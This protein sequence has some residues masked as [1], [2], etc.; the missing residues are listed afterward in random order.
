[1][2]QPDP[3]SSSQ[4]L[5]VVSEMSTCARSDATRNIQKLGSHSDAEKSGQSIENIRFCV[6]L[7]LTEINAKYCSEIPENFQ[8]S[9]IE[10]PCAE[11][12]GESSKTLKWADIS[13]INRSGS[14]DQRGRSYSTKTF[15]NLLVRELKLIIEK[16]ITFQSIRETFRFSYF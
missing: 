7:I 6:A 14:G 13:T 3:T 11:I 4:M 15:G 9:A 5:R 12:C 2:C 1:M 10:L 8:K 16:S